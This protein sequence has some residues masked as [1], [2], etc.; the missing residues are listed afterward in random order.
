M[1]K[2][3]MSGIVEGGTKRPSDPGQKSMTKMGAR[4]AVLKSVSLKGPKG[5]SQVKPMQGN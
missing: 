1:G 5:T 4:D 3:S 2:S